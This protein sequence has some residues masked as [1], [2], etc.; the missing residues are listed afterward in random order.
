M[1]LILFITGILTGNIM[2]VAFLSVHERDW[3]VSSLEKIREKAEEY[4]RLTLECKEGK[5]KL[6]KALI[7]YRGQIKKFKKEVV[8]KVL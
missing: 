8:D 1:G 5:M 3:F 7:E 6:E 2:M 4:E